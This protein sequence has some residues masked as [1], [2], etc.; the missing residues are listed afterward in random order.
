MQQ[1]LLRGADVEGDQAHERS[2][3]RR[4]Q[5]EEW[6]AAPAAPCVPSVQTQ[7]NISRGMVA[8]LRHGRGRIHVD[9]H[10][11]ALATELAGS[12]SAPTGH[13]AYVARTS[14]NHGVPRFEELTWDNDLYIRAIS[15]HSIAIV[16]ADA[17]AASGGQEPPTAAPWVFVE[18][19]SA[20]RKTQRRA[21]QRL[22]RQEWLGLHHG[23][24]TGSPRAEAL[25]PGPDRIDGGGRMP[26]QGAA[27]SSVSATT[28]AGT[29][30]VLASG[31]V[32]AP[33]AASAA[34]VPMVPENALAV[35]AIAEEDL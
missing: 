33:P 25:S 30:P 12:L 8:I 29:T 27:A 11:Y 23:A 32:I 20:S 21:A 1:S 31:V 16:S 6:P 19:G 28:E 17:S 5:V 4:V 15:N 3:V 24:T 13:V 7:E 35:V 22:K 14:K 18:S 26:G 34:S 2:E 9:G 10:G